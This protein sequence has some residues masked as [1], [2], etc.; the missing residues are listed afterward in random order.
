MCFQKK[1]ISKYNPKASLSLVKSV[2]N[3]ALF[4]KQLFFSGFY[5]IPPK[6]VHSENSN[7]RRQNSALLF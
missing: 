3:L 1:C 5:E 7:G 4:K 2:Q 6:T